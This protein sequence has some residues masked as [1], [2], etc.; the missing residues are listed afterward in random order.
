MPV[1]EAGS[2]ALPD[3]TDRHEVS[4]TVVHLDRTLHPQGGW[5][6]DTD[7]FG[8]WRRL[9]V[10]GLDLAPVTNGSEPDPGHAPA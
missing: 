9:V 10:L 6:I 5:T 7:G 4:G 2:P 3:L 1:A 8:R